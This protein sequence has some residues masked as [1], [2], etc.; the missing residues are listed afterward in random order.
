MKV[1]DIT[2]SFSYTDL[3]PKTRSASIER[4]LKRSLISREDYSFLFLLL[5]LAVVHFSAAGYLNT[6][7]IKKLEHI[8]VMAQ[9]PQSLYSNLR[10]ARSRKR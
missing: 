8:E 10:S 3:P 4:S 9:M 7:E 2:L 6:I 5:L 1:G